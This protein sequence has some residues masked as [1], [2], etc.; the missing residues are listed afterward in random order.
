MRWGAKKQTT[1]TKP[2]EV[3]T[4]YVALRGSLTRRHRC[5]QKLLEHPPVIAPAT[6]SNQV[7]DKV[8]RSIVTCELSEG[9]LDSE[10]V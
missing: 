9:H 2:P 10:I 1:A 7:I 8:S 6:A 3:S 4:P 5:I